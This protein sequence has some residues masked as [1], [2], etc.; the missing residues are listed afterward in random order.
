MPK[1]TGPTFTPQIG[2]SG[3]F[4]SNS[5]SFGDRS[6]LR[7]QIVGRRQRD[8]AADDHAAVGRVLDAGL[9]GEDLAERDRRLA[10][11]PD[12]QVADRAA[13]DRLA[14]VV[15]R[16]VGAGDLQPAGGRT[17]RDVDAAGEGHRDAVEHDVERAVRAAGRQARL[18][19]ARDRP[20]AGVGAALRAH[21]HLRV[22]HAGELL[23]RQ[24]QVLALDQQPGLGRVADRDRAAGQDAAEIERADEAECFARDRDFDRAGLDAGQAAFLHA[25]RRLGVEVVLHQRVARL[26][27]GGLE[28]GEIEVEVAL[29]YDVVF[30]GARVSEP[31]PTL[32]IAMPATPAMKKPFAPTP[33]SSA[34]SVTCT[35]PKFR[36]SVGIGNCSRMS[37]PRRMTG[38][39]KPGSS[40]TYDMISADSDQ[41]PSVVIWTSENSIGHNGLNVTLPFAKAAVRLS[42]VM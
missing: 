40:A 34:A 33:I 38:I 29:E 25:E 26:H 8:L 15:D 30:F 22:R 20:F 21:R 9:A 31:L 19:A 11:A 12:V 13:F 41:S 27:L 39:C 3:V 1:P 24:R 36:L 28:E 7:E 42:S 18:A 35:G 32:S 16:A 2:K 23:H 5:G 6:F 10:L 37:S 17:F 4:T 14:L